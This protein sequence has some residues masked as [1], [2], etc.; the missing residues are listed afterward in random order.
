MKKW[1]IALLAA[2]TLAPSALAAKD[3]AI[4]DAAPAWTL[5][6]D[7]GGTVSLKGFQG[8]KVVV[9][10]F[11]PKD[12]TPGCT[13]EM[14]AFSADAAKFTAAGAAVFGISRDS[15]DSHK[16]FKLSC[17]LAIPLLSD[18]EG[19]VATNYQSVMPVVGMF[20]RKTYVID[21]KGIIRDVIDGMPDNKALLATIAKIAKP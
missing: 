12:E 18:M 19:K 14:Q 4:G 21:K 7:R 8:K 5:P 16:K 2:A 20:K 1:A 13:K 17:A 10:A 6:S 11:Y 3:L 9:M 15:L